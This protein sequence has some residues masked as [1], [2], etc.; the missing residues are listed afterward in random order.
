MKALVFNGPRQIQYESFDDPTI[1]DDRNLIIKMQ[2]CSICGSDLHMY[3]GGMIGPFDYSQPAERFCTG[4]EML[5]EVAE[6]G[7]AVRNHRVGDRILISGGIGCGECKRCRAG[8][9]NQCEG[10]ARGQGGTAYGIHSSLN[11]GHAEYVE[12]RH[13]DLGATTIPDGVTD[14]QAILLTD[15]LATG[16]YGVKSIRV[17]PGD[18]VAVIGQGPVGRMAAEA[19]MAVG[20]SR[21]YCI[22]PQESRRNASSSFGGIPLDPADAVVRITEDTKAVGVDGVIEAVGMGPT[23][24]Q[25]VQIA[26]FGGRVS[27]LGVLQPDTPV[28]FQM[29]QAKSV[30]LHPGL[31]GVVDSWAELIPL[32]C[33]GRIKGEGVFTHQMP[34]SEGAEAFRMFEA[35]EDGVIKIMMT[36]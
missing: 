30:S 25:G 6:V 20:A 34:L 23:I 26:R 7:K 24:E 29:A 3:H 14:E 4:H 10:A 33:G 35:R 36:S 1:T 17:Q 19:A 5:G 8:Q 2:R 22:D 21:V 28:P 12:I 9:F 32:V 15:A 27:V 18:S 16:Y 11:G 31:A 13:A